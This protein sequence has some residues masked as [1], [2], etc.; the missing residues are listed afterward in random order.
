L[1]GSRPGAGVNPGKKKKPY[2]K[3]FKPNVDLLA[4]ADEYVNPLPPPKPVD[5]PDLPRGMRVVDYNSMRE[6]LV[7]H[8]TEERIRRGGYTNAGKDDTVYV[9]PGEPLYIPA[10][11]VPGTHDAP[12]AGLAPAHWAKGKAKRE[13]AMKAAKARAEKYAA[14]PKT[15]KP[16]P[17]K[18]VKKKEN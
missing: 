16:K 4:F 2:V 11:K 6:A 9:E 1:A 12:Q 15:E 7:L 10:N 13:R 8:E 3:L 14:E 5:T 17:E 18:K